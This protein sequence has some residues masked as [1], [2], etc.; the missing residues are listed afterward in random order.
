[1][2]D[3]IA[4]MYLG[5]IVEIADR[6]S[7]YLNPRHPYTQALLAA[8]PIPDPEIEAQ[9]PQVAVT[10]EVP[11]ALRP[12]PG[13]RFHTR[14]PRAVDRCKTE[15]PALRDLGGGQMVSCHLA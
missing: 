11:S 3:R 7:L 5:R 12:P 10:G 4:V 9:R 13:C 6:E 15:E 14:C 2:S 1:M 8:V